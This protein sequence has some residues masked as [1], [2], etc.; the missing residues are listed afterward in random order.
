VGINTQ[1]TLND[2]RIKVWTES[3]MKSRHDS[4]NKMSVGINVTG[5]EA[6]FNMTQ[7]RG[8]VFVK[9]L[10]RTL[11]GFGLIMITTGENG[12][13]SSSGQIVENLMTIVTV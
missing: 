11:F 9:S 5:K 3:E 13:A 4:V 12:V 2:V 7:P 6:K 10:I 8:N 1:P